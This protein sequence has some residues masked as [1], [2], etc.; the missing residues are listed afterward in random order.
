MAI[1]STVM[2]TGGLRL[3]ALSQKAVRPIVNLGVLSL[4][5]AL[6]LPALLPAVISS[7]LSK[8]LT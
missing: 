1:V 4:K 7:N 2:G 3:L 6:W 5:F 8:L